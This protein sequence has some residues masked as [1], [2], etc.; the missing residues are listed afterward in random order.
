MDGIDDMFHVSIAWTLAK[1][2]DCI[3]NSR[4][5]IQQRLAGIVLSFESIVVKIGNII[6]AVEL[7]RTSE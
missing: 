4:K 7:L 6:S 2:D 5:D 1:P 3:I